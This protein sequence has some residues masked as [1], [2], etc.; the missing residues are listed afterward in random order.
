M[1]LPTKKLGCPLLLGETLEKELRAYLIDLGKAGGVVNAE[2]AKGLVRR[3]DSRF[4]AEMEGTWFSQRTGPI[5]YLLG[6]DL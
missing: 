4:L 6:W 1:E 2:I 5:I 3:K